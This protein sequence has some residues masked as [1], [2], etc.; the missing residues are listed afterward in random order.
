MLEG[1]APSPGLAT[2]LLA[3][4]LLALLGFPATAARPEDGYDLWL[5]Y[6]PVEAQW[7]GRYAGSATALV[8]DAPSPTLR[9]ARDELRRGIEGL[10]ST[11]L[12]NRSGVDGDGTIVFGTPK[13]S[14]VVARLNL[15]LRR[16]GGD[17]FLIRSVSINGRRATVIAANSD[18]GV[19]YGA[20]RLL[21]EM[22][23]RQ[24]IDR[25]DISEAPHLKL[26]LLNH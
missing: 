18:I 9:V 26:R 7:Q 19:L 3:L 13:S 12:P 2:R 8:G 23:T 21:R 5:R 17:G 15:P 20:Y 24:P 14:A 11:S 10:L 1:C 4:V 25:L 22:Q 16:L 6:Q